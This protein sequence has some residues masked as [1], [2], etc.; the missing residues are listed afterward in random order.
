MRNSI[1]L[2]R[3]LLLA[4]AVC[5]HVLLLP[6][7]AS[8]QGF[9]ATDVIRLKDDP[10]RVGDMRIYALRSEAYSG[11]AVIDALWSGY[12]WGLPVVTYSFYSDAA[13]RDDYYGFENVSEVSETV[14]SHYRQIF[15]WL[16]SVV[17]VEFQE[18]AESAPDGYGIIR[19]MLS[20]GPSYAYSYYP[21]P[22]FP[23]GLAGDIHLNANYQHALDLN[24]WETP[25]GYHG[26]ATLVHELGH[27]LG[28]KHSFE[29]GAVLP[30][31]QDNQ[32][33]T[34]MTY[35]FSDYSPATFMTYDV[36]ALQYLYGIPPFASGRT[37][38]L[39]AESIDRYHVG[40]T[41]RFDSSWNFKQSL[42]DPDG[43]DTLDLSVLNH[44]PDGYRIDI[45]AGGWLT[46]NGGYD[47]ATFSWGIALC[48]QSSLE[49]VISSSSD[50]T[51]Y[52]NQQPN[53]V[54]GYAPGRPTGHDRIEGAEAGDAIDLTRF[55]M[56]A[57]IQTR[58]GNDLVL[59]L[60]G[61]GTV[62]I[63][64]YFTG[65]KPRLLFPVSLAPIYPLLFD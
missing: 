10:P 42:W 25:P 16:A 48:E 58:D 31:E 29:G 51:I 5:L 53:R 27:A 44:D 11:D 45:R 26:Y 18:V 59:D 47:V 60:A 8:V 63:V 34:V 41:L 35:A 4:V 21:S 33:H 62:R 30:P 22:S 32:S 49:N 65:N 20:D 50:D 61:S 36:M 19:I 56:A 13:F 1:R 17:N 40:E 7:V 14:K 2:P 15:Q 6:P 3:N 38:Y 64:G 9:I 55:E 54:G 43:V 23:F 39:V 52:L 57:V 37:R 24:G 46:R 12:R 28:L